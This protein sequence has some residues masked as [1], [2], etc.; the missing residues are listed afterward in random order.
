MYKVAIVDDE[1]WVVESFRLSVDWAQLGLEVVGVAYNGLAAYDLI[2][3]AKPDIVLTDIRMP[4]MGGLE[5]IGR[6]NR[7]GMNV[8]FIVISGHAE[9]SYAQK[10]ML[11]GALGYCLKPVDSAELVSVLH[12]AIQSLQAAR[13]AKAF[14]LFDLI[15]NGPPESS[16]MISEDLAAMRFAPVEQR[17]VLPLVCIALEPVEITGDFVTISDRIGN[18]KFAYLLQ[19]RQQSFHPAEISR[20]VRGDYKSIGVGPVSNSIQAVKAA[21]QDASIAAYQYF[22]TGAG[23]VFQTQR[24]DEEPLDTLLKNVVSHIKNEE[25]DAAR[26]ALRP[27]PGLFRQQQYNIV[28]ALYFYNRVMQV[29]FNTAGEHIEKCIH[30]FAQLADN[31]ST[32]DEMAAF[33]DSTIAANPAPWKQNTAQKNTTFTNILNYVNQNFNRDV[34][35]YDLSQRFFTNPSYISQLFKKELGQNFTEYVLALR[36]K[37]ARELLAK[38]G[39]SL[40]YVAQETGYSDY[41][42]FSRVFKKCCGKAPSQYQEEYRR[43]TVM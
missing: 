34:T 18:Y 7:S 1:P 41:F 13:P 16:G 6:V 11:E 15:L 24:L 5:L 3:D 39:L 20:H 26:L 27:L 2:L 23:G 8:K 21:I 30:S 42:Y 37:Y 17:G 9:F 25:P 14:R 36:M 38:P 35:I 28:H 29:L 32:V 10:A 43:H 40:E 12:K 31:Y 19:A 4:N 22:I 33:L